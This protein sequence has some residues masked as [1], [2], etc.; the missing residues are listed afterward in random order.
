LTEELKT[1]V[2]VKTAASTN[3]VEK[4]GYPSVED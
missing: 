4:T 1:Y 3:G 2:G